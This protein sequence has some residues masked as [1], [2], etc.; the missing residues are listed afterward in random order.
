NAHATSWGALLPGVRAAI[1]ELAGKEVEVV[2]PGEW[3]A[4]LR[5]SEEGEKSEEELAALVAKRPALKLLDFFAGALVEEGEES[6]QLDL[7]RTMDASAKLR[8]V[9]EVGDVWMRKW[10]AEWLHVDAEVNEAN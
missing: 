6:N 5:R 1:E 3:L 8:E 2:A 9:E 4:R 10:I 7:T